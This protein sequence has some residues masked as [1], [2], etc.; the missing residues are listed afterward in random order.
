MATSTATGE[1]QFGTEKGVAPEVVL[2]AE[3]KSYANGLFK[4]DADL[5]KGY[6][7]LNTKFGEQSTE[8]GTLRKQAE[9]LQNQLTAAN[10][11]ATVRI[12]EAKNQEPPTDF[13]KMQSDLFK[14]LEDGDITDVEYAKSSNTLTA[15]AVQAESQVQLN[16]AIKAMEDK[17]NNILAERDHQDVVDQ[18]YKSNEGFEQ[19]QQSGALVQIKQANP[20]F[21]DVS[22]FLHLQNQQLTQQ[23]TD[24]KLAQGS[25]DAGKVIQDPG[26]S[27]KTAPKKV[28]GEAAIKASMLKSL[29]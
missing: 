26:A 25:T 12:E 19:A 29:E 16:T 11:S 13:E 17:T 18:F 7:D 2:D 9:D 21:D 15:Q 8:V 1:S 4:N 6:S 28:V 27:M 14:Q 10:D 5:E 20:L 3:G 23:L 24:A 22:A